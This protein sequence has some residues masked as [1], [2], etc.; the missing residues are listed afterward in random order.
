MLRAVAGYLKWLEICLS[1]F[2]RILRILRMNGKGCRPQR[3]PIGALGQ[4]YRYRYQERCNTKS[5]A[6]GTVRI[7]GKEFPE[8]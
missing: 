5:Q 6:I 4:V 1:Y 2:L 3:I 8:H 7:N